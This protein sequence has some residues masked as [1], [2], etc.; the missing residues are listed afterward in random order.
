MLAR[1]IFLQRI[2][3]RALHQNYDHFVEIFSESL[4]TAKLLAKIVSF[5]YLFFSLWI[6]RYKICLNLRKEFIYLNDS[7]FQDLF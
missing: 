6:R 3:E 2:F 1:L 5:P 7:P 4:V